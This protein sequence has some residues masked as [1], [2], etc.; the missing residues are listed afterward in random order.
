MKGC[1]K[2][3]RMGE[4]ASQLL[5][6]GRCC[7]FNP[8]GPGCNNPTEIRFSNFLLFVLPPASPFLGVVECK[9]YHTHPQ[10]E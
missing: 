7:D 10:T 4:W 8:E 1:N 6:P 3:V 9:L 2:D 5:T